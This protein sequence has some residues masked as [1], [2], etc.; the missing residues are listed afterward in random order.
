LWSEL[1]SEGRTVQ[2]VALSDSNASW[3]LTSP[4]SPALTMPLFR[5]PSPA[6]TAWS[7]L[8]AGAVKHD[9]FVFDAAGQKVLSWK[10]SARSVS[11][12]R[13]DLGAAVR[14]LPR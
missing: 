2:F 14:A 10:A 12:W 13:S 9:T 4:P 1:K 6:R 3:F 8:E 5:D 7:Q 11:Q